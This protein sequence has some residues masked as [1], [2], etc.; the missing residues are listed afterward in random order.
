MLERELGKSHHAYMSAE[1]SVNDEVAAIHALS[2]LDEAS[3]YRAV[4][5]ALNRVRRRPEESKKSMEL[6]L[7]YE[8]ESQQGLLS[9]LESV[10]RKL[11]P[12]KVLDVV[13]KAIQSKVNEEEKPARPQPSSIETNGEAKETTTKYH[14]WK[15]ESS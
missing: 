2:H 4:E 6:T 7:K 9:I 3:Q 12:E 15:D 1:D 11:P 8:A 5:I 14:I 10:A 13:T